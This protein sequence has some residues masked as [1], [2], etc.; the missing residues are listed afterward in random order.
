MPHGHKLWQLTPQKKRRAK[1][2]EANHEDPPNWYAPRVQIVYA[3]HNSQQHTMPA[4]EIENC[5][6]RQ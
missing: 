5:T 4:Y 1:Q 6:E 2:I 3:T